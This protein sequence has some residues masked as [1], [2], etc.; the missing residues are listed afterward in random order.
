MASRR[1]EKISKIIQTTVSE[2]IQNHLSDP[3]ITGLIGV[4]RVQVS[5]DLRLARVFL[6]VVGTDPK[7]EGLTLQAVKHARGYIQTRLADTLTTRTCPRL[8]FQLD[9]SIKKG[10]VISHILDQIAA[11]NAAQKSGNP[12][13][14]SQENPESDDER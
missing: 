10:F 6:S 12:P 14:P 3:R 2:V 7:Q 4:T 1:L 11:E 5:P 13:E 8:D 9:E